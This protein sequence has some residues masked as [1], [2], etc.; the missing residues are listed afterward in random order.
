[1]N[2]RI[3]LLGRRS[4]ICTILLLSMLNVGCEDGGK[5]SAKKARVHVDFLVKSAKRDVGEVRNGLPAG[6][7]LL[8][9]LFDE[10][11]P[12]L[13][14]AVDVREELLRVRGANHDLDSAKSTFFL[15]AGPDG[16]ILRNNLDTDEMAGKNLFE[17]Y[18]SAKKAHKI[19]YFEFT[20]SWEIARGV[21]GRPDAQWVA[22]AS[23][24]DPKGKESGLFAA[25]WSWASY[26]YRLEMSLR[27][28]I[29]GS[30]EEG[31]KVPLLYVYLLVGDQSYGT[32]ISPMI[33][34]RELLKLKPLEKVKGDEI[35]TTP[36]T[37][38]GRD[39][40]VA[41]QRVH[42][43]GDNVLIAVLRSET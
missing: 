12:E 30:T 9:P 26:A 10:V 18:P 16:S 22:V 43:L 17:V 28:D 4:A 31:H 35:W 36:I 21:N 24:L 6:A 33:N 34:G 1:M 5:Q 19:G 40:G 3:P 8:A 37:I 38:E 20:G 39:F 41:M 23:I 7:K 15:V 13:P 25:G 42:E 11:A 2:P 14:A 32:P 29:L 27:S